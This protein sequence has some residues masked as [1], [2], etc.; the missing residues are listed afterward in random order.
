MQV[1]GD[2]CASFCDRA[3]Q[4][5]CDQDAKTTQVTL[6]LPEVTLC[7]CQ[8]LLWEGPDA[9]LLVVRTRPMPASLGEGPRSNPT[10]SWVQLSGLPWRPVVGVQRDPLY[11]FRL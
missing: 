3:Q 4:Q 10:E 8:N 1:P 5:Q 7:C 6:A 2:W 9:V 11:S